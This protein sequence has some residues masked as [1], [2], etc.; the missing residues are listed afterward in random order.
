MSLTSRLCFLWVLQHRNRQSQ[1]RT[2]K[3]NN[4]QL[5][6][7]NFPTKS[8]DFSYSYL[9]QRSGLFLCFLSICRIRRHKNPP[10]ILRSDGFWSRRRHFMRGERSKKREI[11]GGFCFWVRRPIEKMLETL[12]SMAGWEE[13]L[14]VIVIVAT[15]I[16]LLFVVQ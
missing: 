10:G 7:N 8:S 16:A 1:Q 3:E 6:K 13:T 2:Q 5:K 12:P 14:W 15:I 9:W 11:K 4:K